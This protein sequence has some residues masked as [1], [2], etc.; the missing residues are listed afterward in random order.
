MT[1]LLVDST[2]RIIC[3][4]EDGRSATGTGFFYQLFDSKDDGS[5]FPSIVTNKHVIEGAVKGQVVINTKNEDGTR[6]GHYTFHINN[7][8]KV[9][10]SH[11][12][13]N[14]DLA[15]FPIGPMLNSFIEKNNISPY[16]ACLN[17]DLIPSSKEIENLKSIEDIIMIGYPNSLWDKVNNVPIIRK[18]ITATPSYYNY[19]NKP[20]ILIDV[21]S[22]PG[23]SG[24]PVFIYN[25]YYY[26][27][28]N[29]KNLFGGGRLLFL[30]VLFAGFTQDINGKIQAESV[31]TSELHYS[32][33]SKMPI[34]L[35]IIIKAD[36]LRDFENIIKIEDIK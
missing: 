5:L 19:E 8:D 7:F 32:I 14:V 29:E 3:F 22:F 6:G 36:K 12:E 1:E 28:K 27:G 35:G 10:I 4:F 34:N 26:T 31:P 30:G 2:V 16:Y 17:S 24:S 33:S 15:L 23:S 11:P 9:W 25:E 13:E 20:Q 18:G 21:A